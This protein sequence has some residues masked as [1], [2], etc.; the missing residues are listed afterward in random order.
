MVEKADLHLD[1][2]VLDAIAIPGSG[3]SRQ[4]EVQAAPSEV[5]IRRLYYENTFTHTTVETSPAQ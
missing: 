2:N 1:N 5:A 4:S 3:G